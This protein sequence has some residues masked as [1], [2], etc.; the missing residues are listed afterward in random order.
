MLHR[1]AV[2]PLAADATVVLC[3]S[4]SDSQQAK[5]EIGLEQALMSQNVEQTNHNCSG[6]KHT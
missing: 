3:W 5:A 2:L 6:A 4:C 1:S